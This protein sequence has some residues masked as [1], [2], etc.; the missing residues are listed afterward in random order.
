MAIIPI[1]H[2]RVMRE[3]LAFYTQVLDFTCVGGWPSKDEPAYVILEREGDTLHLS[4]LEGGAN[5]SVGVE[6]EDAD[7]L[8]RAYLARGLDVSGKL[9]SPVHQGPVDQTWGNREFYVD[10]PSGNTLRF[11]QAR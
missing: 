2:C 8:F 9:Q 11:M 7:A 3:A 5:Q 1:I 10:D 4:T 6:I